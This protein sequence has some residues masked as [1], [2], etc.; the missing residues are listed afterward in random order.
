MLDLY[1]IYSK[2]GVYEQEDTELKKKVLQSLTLLRN[3][4]NSTEAK[5]WLYLNW[6]LKSDISNFVIACDIN[7]STKTT[8]KFFNITVQT[9]KQVKSYNYKNTEEGKLLCNLN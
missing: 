4:S 6:K 3:F 9:D 8:E 2:V 7:I 1:S 5:E